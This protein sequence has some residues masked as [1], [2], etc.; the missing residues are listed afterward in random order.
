MKF[1]L[2]TFLNGTDLFLNFEI[3]ENIQFNKI[4]TSCP[5]Q[6]YRIYIEIKGDCFYNIKSFMDSDD[7]YHLL[8]EKGESVLQIM[9]QEIN[10]NNH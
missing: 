2:L 9:E 8:N 6:I 3:I 7:I 4:E 5:A 10:E 1:L